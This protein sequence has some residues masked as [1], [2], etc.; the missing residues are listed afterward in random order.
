MSVKNKPMENFWQAY[1]SCVETQRV[2]PDH[3]PF[4]VRWVKVFEDYLPEKRLQDRNGSD[5]RAFLKELAGRQHVAEWQVHQ[6]RHAL[7]LFY[8]QFLPQY[9]PAQQSADAS[10]DEASVGRERFRDVVLP[11]E[12][13]RIYG[14][15]R[16]FL[17]KQM[18]KFFLSHPL[19]T[20]IR[21]S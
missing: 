5:V 15:G 13:E 3:A 16:I 1:Q 19:R 21:S 2:N 10:D 7:S 12:V 20:T 8:E 11:G 18:R 6:A 4:Y 9:K 14:A 17:K